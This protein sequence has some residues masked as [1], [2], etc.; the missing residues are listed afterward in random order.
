MNANFGKK[1]MVYG[2]GINANCSL[3]IASNLPDNYVL[4]RV[5][6]KRIKND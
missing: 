3:K 4:C 6:T 1:C 5:A 2:I